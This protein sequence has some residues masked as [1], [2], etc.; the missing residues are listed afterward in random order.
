VD[1]KPGGDRQVRAR[2]GTEQAPAYQTVGAIGAEHPAGAYR[3]AAGCNPPVVAVA[4]HVPH[5]LCDERGACLD[6]RSKERRVEACPCCDDELGSLGRTLVE[7]HLCT[8]RAVLERGRANRDGVNRDAVDCVAHHIER[9]SGHPAAARLF[10]WV[11]GIEHRDTGTCARHA[12]GGAAAGRPGADNRNVEA[13]HPCHVK[14]ESEAMS[15]PLVVALFPSP[16]AVAAAVRMLHASGI[17]REQISIISRNHD[18]ES[19]LAADMDVTP[20]A[21]I[22][23]SAVAARL[24]ELSGFIL[25]AIALVL[26]G[27]GPIV[28]AGPLSSG[29]G[30]AA[31]HVAGGIA[32][33]LR[34]AGVASARA[35]ALEKA[36]KEGAILL[37]VHTIQSEVATV[38]ALL[39]ASG[40]TQLDTANW[41]E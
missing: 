34:G 10:A 29:L 35:E 5:P 30:E 2:K 26:P 31:G 41:S 18:E 14:L 36:V 27:I 37:G 11:T 40:A 17:A 7:G 24:G 39:Q 6:G 19:K 1:E 12:P 4:R 13:F 8:A 33:A 20:G 32:S 16:S 22:E 28:A 38:R 3:E 15:H 23:D 9:A 21:D 25:A